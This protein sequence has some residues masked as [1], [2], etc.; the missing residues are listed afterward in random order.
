M[1]VGLAIIGGFS[2]LDDVGNLQVGKLNALD[3]VA[4]GCFAVTQVRLVIIVAMAVAAQGIVDR[5]VIDTGGHIGRVPNT[6]LFGVGEV[7]FVQGQRAGCGGIDQRRI[8][9]RNAYFVVSCIHGRNAGN[10]HHQGQTQREDFLHGFH[11]IVCSFQNRFF[12]V[13]VR[14]HW[15]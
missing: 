10:D 4:K 7:I 6:I 11:R 5:L 8:G 12:R 14:T 2:K 13:D 15:K 9:G 3:C 1:V